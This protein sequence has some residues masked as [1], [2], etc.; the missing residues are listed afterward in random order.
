MAE[1]VFYNLYT[2]VL[3]T[4]RWKICS[5]VFKPTRF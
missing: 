4:H 3:F 2:L 5:P 1:R